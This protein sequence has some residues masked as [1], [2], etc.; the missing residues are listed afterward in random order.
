MELDDP[1]VAECY[2]LDHLTC[3]RDYEPP[4]KIADLIRP[5]NRRQCYH[6]QVIQLMNGQW[7][8]QWTELHPEMP[9]PEEY[10]GEAYYG[11][12][13]SANAARRAYLRLGDDLP[14]KRFELSLTRQQAFA[15]VAACSLEGFEEELAALL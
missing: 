4:G 9:P 13:E 5:I 2:D 14:P 6:V 12:N 3:D 8:L 15:L 1:N 10:L 11:M 7:F